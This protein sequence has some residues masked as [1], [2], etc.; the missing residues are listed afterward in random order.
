M[1]EIFNTYV[2]KPWKDYDVNDSYYLETIYREI[3]SITHKKTQLNLF[4]QNG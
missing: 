4:E 3:D 1:Q 2:E